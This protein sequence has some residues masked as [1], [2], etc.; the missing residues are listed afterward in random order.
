ML[1][2]DLKIDKKPV[3]IQDYSSGKIQLLSARSKTLELLR[4]ENK[5]SNPYKKLAERF[6]IFEQHFQ[7]FKKRKSKEESKLDSAELNE[8]FFERICH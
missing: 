4:Q 1:L 3:S 7:N 2:S 6:E 5:N 8:F